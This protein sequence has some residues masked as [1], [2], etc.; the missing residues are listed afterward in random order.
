MWMMPSPS[1]SRSTFE[2]TGQSGSALPF[3]GTCDV[4]YFG[5]FQGKADMTF[6]LQ[7]VCL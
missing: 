3:I 7:N 6:A 4:C 2:R 5:R 1:Q